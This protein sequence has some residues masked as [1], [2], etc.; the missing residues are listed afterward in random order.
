MPSAT[1][2]EVEDLLS[3]TVYLTFN[4][5]EKNEYHRGIFIT[6]ATTGDKAHSS[7]TLF[8]AVFANN[9]WGLERRSVNSIGNSKSLVLIWRVAAVNGF[10]SMDHIEE[11]L[12]RVPCRADRNTD[13]EEEGRID[14]ILSEYAEKGGFSCVPWTENALRAL[15]DERVINVAKEIRTIVKEARAQAGP[16]D[17]TLMVGKDFGGTRVVN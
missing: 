8:H 7:G 6:S 15:K 5:P 9:I 3:N 2:S 10:F 11:I 16:E 13:N 14:R 12:Q 1:L 17:A 4:Q